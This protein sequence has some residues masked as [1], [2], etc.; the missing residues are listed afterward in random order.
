[1]IDSAIASGK[2]TRPVCIVLEEI[3]I[4]LPRSAKVSYQKIISDKLKKM[5]S[6][7]RSQGRGV[8]TISTT[9]TYG[10]TNIDFRSSVDSVLIGKINY[11]DIKAIIRDYALN[12]EQINV[13][14]SINR[15]EFSRFE[16][17]KQDYCPVFR[18]PICPFALKEEKYPDFFTTWKRTYSDK[19]KSIISFHSEMLEKRNKLWNQQLKWLGEYERSKKQAIKKNIWEI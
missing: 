12:K 17:M 4:L 8:T 7:L 15:Y 5:L 1:M 11:E 18:A 19:L 9:Q 10:Q 16:H 3:K 6:G 13:L 2:V 14:S